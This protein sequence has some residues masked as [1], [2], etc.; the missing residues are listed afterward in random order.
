MTHLRDAAYTNS[1]PRPLPPTPYKRSVFTDEV[2]QELDR[3]IA[4]AADYGLE[5]LDVRSV[6]GKTVHE[7]DD[8]ELARLRRAADAAGLAI[9]S[10][11]PPFMKC[12]V[13]DP[14][15]WAQ[16]KRILD[17]S[18]RAAERLGARVVRGF[19]F[20]RRVGV[21]RHWP[22]IVE[23]YREVAPTIERSGLV[24]GIENEAACML[25]TTEL[26][27]RLLDEVGSPAVRAL[28]DPANGAVDGELPYPDAFERVAPYMVHVHLKD[29]RHARG[30]WEHAVVGQGEVGVVDVCRALAARGYDGWVALETHYRPTRTE[31]D[32][33]SPRGAAF[34]E[35]GEE[36]TRACLDGWRDALERAAT[37]GD[38]AGRPRA[39][40]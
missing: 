3:A 7:L 28:W 4:V 14:D 30:K 35:L 9:P 26:L 40:G 8:D 1:V 21:S 33:R 12:E 13:D 18:L 17:R 29:G 22:R 36:G 24:V 38:T 15:E 27:P 34:S 32:L 37:G 20:W 6:W 16:H 39:P 23:A 25:G 31:A 5:G 10:V 19:T 11:A 2:S